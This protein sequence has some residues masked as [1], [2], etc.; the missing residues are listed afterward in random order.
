MVDSKDGEIYPPPFEILGWAIPILKYE[1]KYV[2]TDEGFHPLAYRVESRLLIVRGCPEDKNCASYFYEWTG[3]RF[4]LIQKA[5][6]A[7][8]FTR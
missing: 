2:P 1:G 6:A 7:S 3:S 5:I 8:L 4:K